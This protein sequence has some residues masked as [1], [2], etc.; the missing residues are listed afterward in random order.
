M[1]IY[2][3]SAKCI[4]NV[5]IH[6]S[7]CLQYCAYVTKRGR[8]ILTI[9]RFR[10]RYTWS[11]YFPVTIHLLNPLFLCMYSKFNFKE[12]NTYINVVLN[13]NLTLCRI[14]KTFYTYLMYLI[15]DPILLYVTYR[16][17]TLRNLIPDSTKSIS[18]SRLAVKATTCSFSSAKQLQA[19]WFNE[20]PT[21]EDRLHGNRLDF[22]N[23]IKLD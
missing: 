20:L 22:A 12:L 4:D 14:Y 15:T 16:R 1:L 9:I 18:D 11:F 17:S 7:T 19:A 2:T 3:Y 6:I 13:M 21:R 5:C 10:P 8:L 23:E